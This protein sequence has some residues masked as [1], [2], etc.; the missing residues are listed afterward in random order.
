MP[1]VREHK[2]ISQRHDDS[3]AR[4][5]GSHMHK[6]AATEQGLPVRQGC[7]GTMAHLL[8]LPMFL[9]H[10][11]QTVGFKSADVVPHLSA[12]VA[13][14]QITASVSDRCNA[15]GWRPCLPSC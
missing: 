10:S 4:L 3:V 6:P 14:R 15:I 2:Y 5:F 9:C 8:F 7:I 12:A 11:W 13:S 1:Q